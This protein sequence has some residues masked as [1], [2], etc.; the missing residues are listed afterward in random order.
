GTALQ[1]YCNNFY[2]KL[3]KG[4]GDPLSYS[5]GML[6]KEFESDN[7]FTWEYNVNSFGLH[8]SPTEAIDTVWQWVFILG[9]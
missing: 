6:E 7:I 2:P 1:Q 9:C 4:H 3:I 5:F 8:V